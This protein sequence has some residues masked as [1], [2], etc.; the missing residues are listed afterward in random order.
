MTDS[1]PATDACVSAGRRSDTDSLSSLQQ[2]EARVRLPSSQSSS[3]RESAAPQAARKASCSS[4]SGAGPGR[5]RA[6][7]PLPANSP[8]PARLSGTLCPSHR[9][10]S[11]FA[12]T[13]CIPFTCPFSDLYCFYLY[14]PNPILLHW[15]HA[16]KYV[17]IFTPVSEPLTFLPLPFHRIFFSYYTL[18]SGASQ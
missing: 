17:P 18:P 16:P 12:L 15:S 7:P 10:A 4:G 5:A 13:P 9:H 11:S 6:A 14:R 8:H 1:P 2:A 3:S